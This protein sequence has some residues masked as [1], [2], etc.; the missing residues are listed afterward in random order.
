MADHTGPKECAL[1]AI[2]DRGQSWWKLETVY[3]KGQ[4]F[5]LE[6]NLPWGPGQ[7]RVCGQGFEPVGFL[8]LHHSGAAHPFYLKFLCYKMGHF[9]Q[10]QVQVASPGLYSAENGLQSN[11]PHL[12]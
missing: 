4:C 10:E 1:L 9:L 3:L 8:H 2:K 12:H 7:V 5:S 11:C 6:G